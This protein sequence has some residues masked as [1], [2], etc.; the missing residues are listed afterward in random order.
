MELDKLKFSIVLTIFC[1]MTVL[2]AVA[3]DPLDP[4]G[5]INIK[6]DILSW[7]PD[8]YVAVVLMNNFQM[9]RQI[10]SP[11]W[12][13]GWTWA[14]KEVIWSMVGAQA[15]DQG[16]CS[17]F[18]GNIPHCC[19]RNPTVVDLLPG[20]PKKQQY[21][22]CCKGGVLASWGQEPTA[23]V[24]SFQLSVGLSG[25]SNTTVALPQNFFLLGPGPGYTCSAATIVSPSV[26]FS[27]DGQR[28][29]QAMMT[30]TVTCSYSQMLVSKNPSCC[31]SLSSFY[32]SKITPC[33]S[34]SCGCQNNENTSCVMSNSRISRV[35]EA[36]TSMLECTSH[37]CPIQVHWHVKANYKEY[38]RVKITVTNFNY[39][40]NFTRWTLVAQHPNFNN[41]TRVYSFLYKSF[42]LFNTINDTA[43]FYGNKKKNDMLL[44]AGRN[45]NV[46]S[47][48]LLGKDMSRYTL[49]HGWV[50]PSRIYFDGDECMMPPPDLYPFL[51]NSA[52]FSPAA[53]STPAI[54]LILILLALRCSLF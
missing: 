52:P 4:N 24:S 20:V 42:M 5:S 53:S 32:N 49:E 47:E 17:N 10:M 48:I 1:A 27:S 29:T 51:P 26:F 39:R 28:K 25:T 31:V 36:S 21:S 23:A 34:C 37:M 50:F 35:E 33:P 6:W 9:Y 38:W 43:M 45:G 46:Q 16:D 2:C 54:F 19:K 41:V 8:G 30:W 18:K 7:T 11:G 13:L 12:T 22:D 40:K 15:T 14:K 3:Y 44:E